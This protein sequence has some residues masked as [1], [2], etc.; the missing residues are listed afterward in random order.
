MSSDPE[1]YKY[2]ID[3]PESLTNQNG[4]FQVIIYLHGI[5]EGGKDLTLLKRHGPW[6]NHPQNQNVRKYLKNYFVIAA[7]LPTQTEHWNSTLILNTLSKI[8]E[9]LKAKHGSEIIDC[10]SVFV[11]GNSRGGRGALELAAL[12]FPDPR[13]NPTDH[14]SRIEFKAAVI[15]CPEEGS[16]SS[17]NAKTKYQFFHCKNDINIHTRYTYAEFKKDPNTQFNVYPGTDHNCWTKTYAN[18]ALYAWLENPDVGQN[19]ISG[20]QACA[21]AVMPFCPNHS[22]LATKTLSENYDYHA[23]DRSEIRL[24]VQSSRGGLCHCTLPKG[25]VSGSVSHKT[26]E[27]LWYFLSGEGEVWRK[28]DRTEE[29]TVIKPGTSISIPAGTTFQFRNTGDGPL[30][31]VIATMPPWPGQDEAVPTNGKW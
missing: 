23:P 5:R 28:L 30:S 12:G 8:F 26:V 14:K 13:L 15:I 25:N 16:S 6:K 19:W 7:Q 24:L 3:P 1:T 17:I 21:E 18:P 10:S 2:D 31:F 20:C 27:E 4:P 22:A 29:T 11:T 9:D